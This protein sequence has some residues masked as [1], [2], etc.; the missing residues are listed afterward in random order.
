MEK[1]HVI[2]VVLGLIAC[3]ALYF[4]VDIYAGM[5]GVILVIALAMSLFIMADSTMLPDVSVRLKEDARGIIVKNRGNAKALSIRLSLI[6]HDLHYT[7]ASLDEDAENVFPTEMMIDKVKVI[8]EY[9]NE[10]G[11][12]YKRTFTISALDK[13]DD[14][15]LKPMFPLFKWK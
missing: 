3:V 12:L 6:P 1:N 15:L 11:D 10:K 7:I 2:L 4:L 8:A 14:D 9:Q 13:P 5:I